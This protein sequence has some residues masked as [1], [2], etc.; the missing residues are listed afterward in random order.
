[1][2]Q[3]QIYKAPVGYFCTYI[4]TIYFLMLFLN[5]LNIFCLKRLINTTKPQITEKRKANLTT[6][7][8]ISK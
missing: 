3:A 4:S 1:M 8:L 5:P 2:T 6:Q 7:L